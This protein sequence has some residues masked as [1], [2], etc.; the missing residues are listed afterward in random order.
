MINK[1]N[2]SLIILVLFSLLGCQKYNL[3]VESGKG[4][5]EYEK[6]EVVEIVADD[7]KT[8]YQFYRWIGDYQYLEDRYDEKTSVKMEK[9]S[10]LLKAE[11]VSINETHI[12]T[13]DG[14]SNS[15]EYHPGD[16][17]RISSDQIEPPEEFYRWITDCNLE[18][19]NII[20]NDLVKSEI[21]I[22]MPRKDVKISA[23]FDILYSVLI[24]GGIGTGKFPK[25]SIVSIEANQA[26]NGYVFDS[27]IGNTSTLSDSTK[28][29]IKFIMPEMNIE[30]EA[31]YKLEP[32]YE[33]KIINGTGTGTFKV[34]TRH[35]ITA[36]PE[37]TGYIF[38][39]WTGDTDILLNGANYKTYIIT[40]PARNITL[41]ATYEKI[42]DFLVTVNKGTGD[43][44]YRE[45]QA[46]SIE[47]EKAMDGWI[48]SHWAG[49]ISL[50]DDQF[51]PL[52]VFIM[53]ARNMVIDAIYKKV[54]DF[55]V[56]INN[57][58][59]GGRYRTGETVS[60]EAELTSDELI[61]SHWEGDISLLED[62][63]DPTTTFKMPNKSVTLS[64]IFSNVTPTPTPTHTPTSNYKLDV[65]EG[66]K[67]RLIIASN[68]PPTWK[69]VFAIG[70]G[71][72]GGGNAIKLYIPSNSNTSVVEGNPGVSCCSGLGLGNL[73]WR[74]RPW[75]GTNGT[76]AS[77]GLS[78]SISHYKITERHSDRLTFE[79]SGKFSGVSNFTRT[80]TVTPRGF[81]TNVVAKYAGTTGKDS[82]WWLPTALNP[83]RVNGDKISVKNADGSTS[84][85]Y[86]TTPRGSKMTRLVLPYEFT[87]PLF[88]PSN[89]SI[90]MK[91]KKLAEGGGGNP[92]NYEFFHKDHN[93]GV[94]LFYPRWNGSFGH[95]NYTFLW[96][97]EFA[98]D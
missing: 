68:M 81:T 92:N 41:E 60:I 72:P 80:T 37:Q 44:R 91:V 55:L 20:S 79:M 59:G 43:G 23:Q 58:T 5:G 97:W 6:G 1:I 64:A 83:S 90:K 47:A 13:V 11:Y 38:S 19:L 28:E 9:L 16:N 15:G 25:D 77:L 27:W 56:T 96:E 18:D 2:A 98:K 31:T 85:M 61:F 45:G 29:K 32:K 93:R 95:T 53:P 17:I 82:M 65:Y 34:G 10:I 26:E 3:T 24:I 71:Y 88:H 33:L 42:P 67:N 8:G 78:S 54:P 40:M 75:G 7:A 63:F 57:G 4:S 36:N 52:T 50:L 14:G 76:R 35:R 46:V 49:D 84:R 48:F 12:L 89:H 62:K 66:T 86:Y 69:V 21:V 94:H 74:W 22:K 30:L 73:E 87:F 70:G 39:G 51:I